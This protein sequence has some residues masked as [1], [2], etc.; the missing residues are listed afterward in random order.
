MLMTEKVL[1]L[2]VPSYNMEDY[3]AKGLE[4][5]LGISNPSVLDVIVVNDGSKD[6]TL[7]IARNF[8][9]RYPD[10]VTVVDKEN[11]NYG[12]CINT[13]LK[14]AKGK[15]IK[16]LD[17]D[18][19]FITNNFEQLL[20]ALSN[21]D[22]DMFFTDL[23]KEYISGKKIEYHF[24]LP[25]RKIADIR[26]VC[27]S[28]AFIDIQMPAI[29]YRTELLKAIKY[30][31]TESISYTD[32]EWCFSPIIQVKTIYYLNI[33]V[34]LYLLGREG[35]T[36]DS[37]VM[38]KRISHTMK[39]FLSMLHS[40][41]GLTVPAYLENFVHTRLFLRACYI[42]DFYLLDNTHKDQLALQAL[43]EELMKCCPTVYN[44]CGKRYYRRHVPYCYIAKWRCGRSRI[45]VAIKTLAKIL[46]SIGTLRSFLHTN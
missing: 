10:I 30:H 12:S 5:V 7:E 39:S 42:Y 18:D 16:I 20:D 8:E 19:R 14:L 4:S 2:I 46:D 27:N 1:S 32:Q 44:L 11:G 26:D 29:T 6:R 37:A 36:M 25:I 35:Q 45:P 28:N 41:E 9:N 33:P 17:A 38:H 40:I 23:V 31:Q 34:Y 13:G 43:D 3:L 22:A 15:Y 21:I 24:D